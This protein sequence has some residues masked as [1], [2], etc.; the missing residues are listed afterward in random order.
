MSTASQ[1]S[2]RLILIFRPLIVSHGTS[3]EVRPQS[4]IMCT[5]ALLFPTDTVSLWPNRTLHQ[6]MGSIMQFL[7]E[8]YGT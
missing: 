5:V 8:F 6:C 3:G 4:V 2:N 7:R 1:S